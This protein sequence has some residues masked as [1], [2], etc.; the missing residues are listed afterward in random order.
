[1]NLNNDDLIGLDVTTSSGSGCLLLIDA[2]T[3]NFFKHFFFLYLGFFCFSILF[4]FTGPSSTT[5]HTNHYFSD[6]IFSSD[7]VHSISHIRPANSFINLYLFI[8]KPNGCSSTQISAS[9][10]YSITLNRRSDIIDLYYN[11]KT[12]AFSFLNNQSTSRAVLLHKELSL[13]HI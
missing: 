13:I 5:S 4:K 8:H 3:F 2:I 9:L 6:D 1:M 12:L 10:N 7:I 11:A